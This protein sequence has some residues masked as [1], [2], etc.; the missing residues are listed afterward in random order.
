MCGIGG[1]RGVDDTCE[2]GSVPFRQAIER[3]DDALE[4]TTGWQNRLVR[5][6]AYVF[7]V[8]YPRN[9]PRSLLHRPLLRSFEG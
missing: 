3:R 8:A 5:R 9:K 2:G 7:R 4:V 1:A 6:S